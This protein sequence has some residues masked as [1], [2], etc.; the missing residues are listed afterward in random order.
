MLGDGGVE[1]V[2]VGQVDLDEGVDRALGLL[3]VEHGDVGG[4]QLLQQGDER[5]PDAGGAAGDD[6]ALALVAEQ[7]PHGTDPLVQSDA[8][9][10][11]GPRRTYERP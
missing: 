8:A 3:D 4:A 6:H 9:R 10:S 7:V 11:G 5:R 1:G 2:L